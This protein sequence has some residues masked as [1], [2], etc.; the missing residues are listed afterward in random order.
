MGEYAEYYI[1]QMLDRAMRVGGLGDDDYDY[2]PTLKPPPT[3]KRC[4]KEH[5]R[6]QEVETP[7]GE[8]WVL[9]EGKNR[10]ICKMSDDEFEDL[11]G[12]V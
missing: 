4:G 8:K 6:W 10:H 7:Q 2:Q 1:D 11:S 12:E 9:F 5:L 3:C